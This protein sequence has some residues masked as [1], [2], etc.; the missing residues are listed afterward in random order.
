MLPEYWAYDFTQWAIKILFRAH[1]FKTVVEPMLSDA[2]GQRPEDLD[3]TPNGF[4]VII[5]SEFRY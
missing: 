2:F 1:L 3:S 5:L 4:W